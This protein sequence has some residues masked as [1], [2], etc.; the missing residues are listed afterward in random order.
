MIEFCLKALWSIRERITEATK[1]DGYVY[2]YD[3]SLPLNNLYSLVLDLRQRLNNKITRCNGFGHV[4]D[5]NIHVNISCPKYSTDIHSLLEPYVFE[6]VSQHKGSI[7]AEHGLG[8]QKRKYIHFSKS[9]EAI[10]SMKLLKRLYDP[11]NI[12]NPYKVVTLN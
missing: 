9:K 11:N 12:L 2:K 5:G 6:W 10:E 4:G 3:V 8:Q 7:S 1:K